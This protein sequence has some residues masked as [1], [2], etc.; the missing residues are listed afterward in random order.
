MAMRETEGGGWV[1]PYEPENLG[2]SGPTHTLR[3]VAT[4][5][6][7]GEPLAQN[8]TRLFRAAWKEF[9]QGNGADWPPRIN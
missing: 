5:D 6:G 4:S 7:Q 9:W 8:W 1:G 3:M 2:S